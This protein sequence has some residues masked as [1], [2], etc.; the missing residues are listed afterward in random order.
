VCVV[1]QLPCRIQ[2]KFSDKLIISAHIKLQPASNL[3]KSCSFR[4]I[5][6][7]LLV[8]TAS[9]FEPLVWG[10]FKRTLLKFHYRRDEKGNKA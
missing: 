6:E 1:A 10:L 9:K 8:E 3:N 4:N 2:A 5:L 7:L